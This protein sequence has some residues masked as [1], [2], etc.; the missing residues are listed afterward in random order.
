MTTVYGQILF[1]SSNQKN[2]YFPH[3]ILDISRYRNA[4]NNHNHHRKPKEGVGK[5]LSC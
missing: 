2:D 1:I 3:L 4:K 5:L